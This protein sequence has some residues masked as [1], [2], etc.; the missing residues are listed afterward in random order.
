MAQPLFKGKERQ[1]KNSPYT[2]IQSTTIKNFLLKTFQNPTE[3]IFELSE[4]VLQNLNILER[5]DQFNEV[6]KLW[7]LK[8]IALCLEI[9]DPVECCTK[10]Y[11]ALCFLEK[12]GASGTY[13]LVGV[14]FMKKLTELIPSSNYD[15]L[16]KLWNKCLDLLL[17][18]EAAKIA[19]QFEYQSIPVSSINF[20]VVKEVTEK[21]VQHYF[22]LCFVFYKALIES[23][24]T[25]AYTPEQ[26]ALVLDLC[27]YFAS[28]MSVTVG[29]HPEHKQI[30]FDNLFD[31]FVSLAQPKDED[32]YLRHL[33]C[34]AAIMLIMLENNVAFESEEVFYKYFLLGGCFP[35]IQDYFKK[36][37]Q[38]LNIEVMESEL[39]GILNSK[40]DPD[41][42][43]KL[44]L[45]PIVIVAVCTEKNMFKSYSKFI[46]FIDLVWKYIANRFVLRFA[47]KDDEKYC[48]IHTPEFKLG[49]QNLLKSEPKPFECGRDYL[50]KTIENALNLYNQEGLTFEDKIFLMYSIFNW[51]QQYAELAFDPSSNPYD[52]YYTLV[53]RLFNKMCS[54]FEDKNY[55]DIKPAFDKFLP[56]LCSPPF[57]IF[58][59]GPAKRANA[60]LHCIKSLA[61]QKGATFPILAKLL[62]KYASDKGVFEG[63]TPILPELNQRK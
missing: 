22:N 31:S 3:R 19:M 57:P 20:K 34:I 41:L 17:A 5:K 56:V 26:K 35:R 14:N 44:N 37:N 45:L 15:L 54:L 29:Q 51:M 23:V 61:S 21:N 55:K 32:L 40:W 50:D 27:Y 10:I 47:Q 43:Q 33:S 49:L 13:A 53:F 8:K 48:F 59:D 25:K 46:N 24:K 52:S 16:F 60:T 30:A 4:P 63:L 36:R 12:N 7:I 1:K 62:F 39:T 42:S 58:G 2:P 6:W 9:Q 38:P 11:D 28:F 18:E